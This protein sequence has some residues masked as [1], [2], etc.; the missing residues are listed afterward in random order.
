MKSS[1]L[2]VLALVAFAVACGA[3]SNPD[4]AAKAGDQ[5]L[6]ATRLAEVI[7]HSGAPLEK[8][9]ARNIAELWVNYQLAGLAAASNDSLS[10]AKVMQDALWSQID[11]IRVK[12]FYENVSKGWDSLSPGSDEQRYANGEAFAA[13]HILV[14]IDPNSTPEQI[15]AAKKKA[16]SILAEAT[17]A[18]FAALAAKSD[19]PGAKERG[20]DLGLFGRGMM[21]PE[22]EKC[23]VAIKPGEISKEVCQTSFGFHVIYRS[24]FSDVAD[25][26]APIAKQ[27]N[28]AIAESTYLAKL[29]TSR[30][31]K[32]EGSAPVK[33]KAIAKNPLGY[34]KDNSALA[35]YKGG[36][37]TAA[38]F[39]QWVMAYPAQ[40][41]IRP[42]LVAA[43]DTLV[44][45]F[46]KQIVRNELVLQQADSAKAQADTGELQVI[47]MNFKSD[48]P[49][50][51]AGLDVDPT[52]LVD[53]A[54]A[55]AGKPQIAAAH[56]DS[57][58]SKLV[59]NEV[60]FVE[61]P[62]PMA[63]ALQ[64]KYSFSINEA[65]LDKA[66]EQAKTLR[67]SADS[68]KAQ[69]APTGATPPDTTRK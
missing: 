16:E 31:V 30:N 55:K 19:E 44:D 56:V 67:A 17:P 26:F 22:F 48:V 66:I 41:Q 12:K 28:V 13:R 37:L 1:R 33:A 52:K 14:K 62:Y 63:H 10:D 50:V 18:N 65:G 69:A 5:E 35:T 27:R 38:R 34:I 46:V 58:F 29:E 51:W 42:Q 21:V 9:V 20:G 49:R 15:G 68:V 8:D 53:S 40:A 11:N 32:V 59:K 45:K 54:N 2:S 36:S 7:A 60:P 47:F 24:P 43:P 61:I 25:K 6:S 3:A 4:V 39:A 57:F 23:V 64:Q